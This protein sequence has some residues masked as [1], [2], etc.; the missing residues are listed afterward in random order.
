MRF[1]LTFFFLYFSIIAIGQSR[2][3]WPY[4]LIKPTSGTYN[5]EKIK[6]VFFQEATGKVTVI[7]KR[8]SYNIGET[9]AI[10]QGIVSVRTKPEIVFPDTFYYANQP[11][12]IHVKTGNENDYVQSFDTRIKQTGDKNNYEFNFPSQGTFS[13]IISDNVNYQIKKIIKVRVIDKP[14]DVTTKMP[15]I[16][17]DR[18]MGNIID[19]RDFKQLQSL[20]LSEGYSF[21]GANLYF[22][23]TSFDNVRVGYINELAIDKQKY[24]MDVLLP[25]SS[26]TIDN[27]KVKDPK[28]D[29][30]TIQGISLLLVDSSDLR[31][32][33]QPCFKRAEFP[34]GEQ[35]LYNYFERYMEIT[36]EEIAALDRKVL[37][38]NLKVSSTGL[39]S[40]NGS[41]TLTNIEKKFMD[42]FIKGP[43]WVPASYK[44]EPVNS[45]LTQ[46]ILLQ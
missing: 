44:S 42:L 19:F 6:K 22:S 14:N 3:I 30:I 9:E 24:F 34:G 28:G 5:G 15:R 2:N 13:I 33:Y 31:I 20:N 40:E 46:S 39:V 17:V 10:R 35:A 38:F 7:T 4:R 41:S 18:E 25:G 32:N 37:F 16:Y 12:I 43:A 26:I 1:K 23:G 45:I 27:I 21:A 29:T 8:S 11:N 36:K